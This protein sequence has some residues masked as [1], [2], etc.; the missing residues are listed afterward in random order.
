MV[1]Q[2]YF[3]IVVL[4]LATCFPQHSHSLSIIRDIEIEEVLNELSRPIIVAAKL[5]P[6][7]ARIVI[8]HDQHVNA[9]VTK[10]TGIYITTGLLLK[11]R[12]PLELVSIIAHELGHIKDGHI[13]NSQ[14]EAARKSIISSMIMLG[15]MGAAMA[16]NLSSDALIAT[17]ATS[18]HMFERHMLHY[19]RQNEIA[20][21]HIAIKMLQ[22]VGYPLE[23]FI[24][25]L[26]QLDSSARNNLN[27]HDLTHPLTKERL[28]YVKQQI[29]GYIAKNSITAKQ[30]YALKMA[31]SKLEGFISKPD[32]I[33]QNS[34]ANSYAKA[35]A[36]HRKFEFQKAMNLID[37]L[38]Q[39][40]PNNPYFHELKG[41]FLLENQ[42]L[43]QAIKQYST[44][45]NLS[46]SSNLIKIDL[47]IAKLALAGQ[48]KSSE[49]IHQAIKLLKQVI[50]SEPDNILALEQLG[51]AYGKV[52]KL[53]DAYSTLSLAAELKEDHGQARRFKDLADSIPSK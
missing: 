15:S 17:A 22:K 1:I 49:P 36:H 4:V 19:S 41:Q 34:T 26:N 2:Y 5:D 44:A 16:G 8:V 42:Q 30:E 13:I 37:S 23:G 29:H 27:P 53:H 51:A 6:S 10:G 48:N 14:Q 11:F 35:I 20:A 38:L 9:F 24:S 39:K 45:I 43:A 21:D 47:A 12:Q 18:S 50:H 28:S 33:L 3:T 7:R 31:I 25:V 46:P 32:Y 52:N 40:E